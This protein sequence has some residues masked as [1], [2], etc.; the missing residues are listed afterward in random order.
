M[1]KWGATLAAGVLVYSL[2]IVVLTHE[3]FP[4]LD[5]YCYD[6]RRYVAPN[7]DKVIELD[8]VIFNPDSKEWW[9]FFEFY[10]SGRTQHVFTDFYNP[11]PHYTIHLAW[12]YLPPV[13]AYNVL[14][15]LCWLLAALFACAAT[16][17]LRGNPAGALLAG[18][19]FGFNP[20]AMLTIRFG[21]LDRAAFFWIPLLLLVMVLV[22][23]RRSWAW[24]ASAGV[25]LAL[26]GL[27]NQYY[28]L[29]AGLALG[30][31]AVLALVAPS[32]VAGAPGR[33]GSLLRVG[34]S[35]GV[36]LL[37]L[38][39]MLI[40]EVACL[41]N[42]GARSLMVREFPEG[43][44]FAHWWML[45]VLLFGLWALLGPRPWR[46]RLRGKPVSWFLL[47]AG[48]A[49][50]G[51]LALWAAAPDSLIE[52]LRSFPVIW[53]LQ[54]LT[55]SVLLAALALSV[56]AGLG[57]AAA[58]EQLPGIALKAAV[59]L[60]AAALFCGTLVQTER[61][62]QQVFAAGISME[63]P[64]GTIQ[65][66][67]AA[68]RGRRSCVIL[69]ILGADFMGAR[70][71]VLKFYFKHWTGMH[72]RSW[73][74]DQSALMEIYGPLFDALYPGQR[75]RIMHNPR[76]ARRVSDCGSFIF[77]DRHDPATNNLPMIQ[78]LVRAKCVQQ[79]YSSEGWLVVKTD[80]VAK[81][82]RCFEAL[83]R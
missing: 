52:T 50:I 76:T 70:P 37:L 81:T 60:V 3:F 44:W 17:A 74:L 5:T 45:P 31:W 40:F 68:G 71:Q 14:L 79:A 41:W 22:R 16:L 11:L 73:D 80:S 24:P 13:L 63:I 38:S 9:K 15:G 83:A 36:G 33:R 20:L 29:A 26:C 48:A 8:D 10:R 19:L 67:E 57:L 72:F 21:S 25:V 7:F 66:V 18:A 56:L 69:E 61:G 55:T 2:L 4:L 58:L 39:P 23:R 35:L 75:G 30:G 65:Q 28:L 42:A 51:L 32:Q 78:R 54:S 64:E 46:P 1:L 43:R 6:T 12:R 27:T 53:R 62:V 82:R 49:Q 34:A 77:V 47:L 59:V